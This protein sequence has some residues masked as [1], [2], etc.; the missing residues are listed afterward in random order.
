MQSLKKIQILMLLILLQEKIKNMKLIVGLGNPGKEYENTIH[1]LGF[2]VI[3]L[4]AKKLGVSINKG[5]FNGLYTQ[6]KYNGEIVFLLKPL[7]Y[8]NLSGQAVKAMADYYKIAPKDII[9]VCDDIDL[10]K[11]VCRYKLNGS[12]GTHNGLKNIVNML[13]SQDFQRVKIG[14]GNDKS[15]DLKD[16]VLS[17]IDA[18]SKALISSCYDLAIEKVLSKVGNE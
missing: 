11:G 15:M 16:Y 13:N 6:T 7:T 2:E 18:E 3:D 5:K 14:A 10:P 12:G 17:K 4:I 9:V 1:N 8:M